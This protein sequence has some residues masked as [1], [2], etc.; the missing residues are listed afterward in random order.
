MSFKLANAL[1]QYFDSF[2][3]IVAEQLSAIRESLLWILPCLMIISLTLFS[4]SLGEF[5]FG[6]DE[7]WVKSLF[8]LYYFVNEL[9][10]ILLTAALSY[11]LAMRWRLPRPPIALVLI[12]YLS[13]FDQLFGVRDTTV[14]FELLISLVTPLYAVPL[15]AYI[16]SLR[17]MKFVT[18]NHL[19]RI[20]KESLNLILP[21]IIVGIIVL[22]VNS[23]LI[24]AIESSDVFNLF[25]INY[26]DSPLGF[27]VVFAMVNSLF[28]FVGIHGY[29]ALL[30]MVDVLQGAV[31]S[32][33][34]QMYLNGTTDYI[35]NHSSMAAFTFLG[36]AGATLGLVLALL[37]FSNNKA[38]RLIALA[39][40]PLGLLNINEV[41]LFGL[42]IIFNPRLFIPFLLAP[43]INTAI[44]YLAIGGGLVQ[45]PVTGMPFS[46]PVF[47]N[48]W[49][50]TQGD[51]NACFLQ[52]FNI[53]VS[54]LVYIPFVLFLNRTTG[55]KTILFSS[56][57][58]TYSRRAEEAHTLSDDRVS[59]MALAQKREQELELKLQAFSNQ[60]FCLQYQPQICRVTGQVIGCEA[61]IRCVDKQGN[62]EYP[63]SFLPEFEQAG[64]MKDIDRWVVIQAVHD[65]KIAIA[66]GWAIPTSVNL[67]AGTIL[68]S[69]LMKQLTAYISRVGEYIHVEITEESLLTDREKVAASLHAL[70]RVGAK[71]CVDDFGAGY[72]SLSYLSMFDIDVIKIDRS[73]IGTLGNVKGQ[74]VFNGLISVA[75]DLNLSVVIEGVETEEQLERIPLRNHLAIQGWYYSKS[76]YQPELKCYI[77]NRNHSR[78]E[79][80]LEQS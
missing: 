13:I 50:V 34:Y 18:N 2:K 16:Y 58:T 23:T 79:M 39:S 33:Q 32:A 48:A 20:V 62:I 7:P 25:S 69:E 41:L 67:T 22:L 14:V 19:G 12:V 36:G 75:Q 66:E 64:L 1:G 10:P 68:D 40:L 71:I 63:G 8:E 44:A 59:Q 74:K 35:L 3:A 51:I 5:L 11:I 28:W 77:A 4:A 30:P 26:D 56:L 55:D 47:F 46:S 31:D 38:H 80:M 29:Y 21:S 45:V 57:D 6:N 76:L 27:G 60:E 24:I 72:S 15:I 53:F 70:H 78:S 61:L 42:P 54:C 17:W 43:V 37:F 49:I 73:F 65:L 9:F 52:L